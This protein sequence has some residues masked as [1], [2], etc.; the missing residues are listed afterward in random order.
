MLI[1]YKD[2]ILIKLIHRFLHKI[3]IFKMVF[4]T[5]LYLDKNGKSVSIK[6]T[7]V[8]LVTGRYLVYRLVYLLC[9]CTMYVPGINVCTYLY[10]CTL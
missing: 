10:W 1:Y 5:K 6:K 4:Y 9:T 2:C 7:N 8:C 3:I